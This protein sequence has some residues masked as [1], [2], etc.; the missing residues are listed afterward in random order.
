MSWNDYINNYLVNNQDVSTQ[1]VAYNILENAAIVGSGD[2]TIWASTPD[3]TFG[4]HN[5]EVEKDDGTSETV[6]VNEF[7]NLVDAFN[8]KGVCSKK[9]GI[10]INK[11]KYYVASSDDDKNVL[12]LKKNGGGAAVAKSGLAFIIGIYAS[13]NKLKN[14][15]GIEEPQSPGMT[16]RVV[17]NLQSFLLEN[18]L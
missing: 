1:K 2:G 8:N 9:G 15:N 4:T 10:R 13:K 16:N 17:E 11:E 12:Y 14:Y 18:S 5:V 3:F 7:E 6:S